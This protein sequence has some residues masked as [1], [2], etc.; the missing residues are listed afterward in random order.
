MKVKLLSQVYTNSRFLRKGEVVDL[1]KSKAENYI[2]RGLG[3]AFEE[4][5]PNIVTKE[6]KF[7]NTEVVKKYTLESLEP[8]NMDQLKSICDDLGLDYSSVGGKRLS[9]KKLEQ[10]ILDNQ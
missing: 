5:K 9:Q 6:E 3:V 8:L 7:S 2:K 4:T 10:F 1:P